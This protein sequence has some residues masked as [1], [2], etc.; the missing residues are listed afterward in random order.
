VGHVDALRLAPFGDQRALVDDDTGQV[1]TILDRTDGLAE[2]FAAEGSVVV[3]LEIAR[4]LGLACDGEV[5]R[6]FQQWRVDARLRRRLALPV[7]AR[8][9][10]RLRRQR[11]RQNAHQNG[12]EP[13][14]L[15]RALLSCN[16]GTITRHQPAPSACGDHRW[17]P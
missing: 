2:R 4:V 9:R 8:E 16:G 15:H 14:A 6:V 13:D 11:H 12:A 1:A 7:G 10:L 3:E 17:R 5:D